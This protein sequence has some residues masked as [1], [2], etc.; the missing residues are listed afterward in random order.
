MNLPANHFELPQ[1]WGWYRPRNRLAETLRAQLLCAVP[2]S[3]LLS[4]EIVAYHQDRNDVLLRHKNQPDRFTV[5]HLT[6]KPDATHSPGFGGTFSQFSAREQ[7][8]HEVERRM[9]ESPNNIPGVC[10][11]C[12]SAVID[13]GCGGIWTGSVKSKESNGPLHHG[14]CKTCRALL[15]ASPTHEKAKE[16]VFLWRFWRWDSP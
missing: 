10:P 5:I 3:D 15:T 11:V 12:F 2:E 1:K 13:E 14:T 4:V 8:R 9:I 7:K 6:G 16:G